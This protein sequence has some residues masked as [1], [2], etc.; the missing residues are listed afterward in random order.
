[1]LKLLC[2]GWN[3][4]FYFR[5]GEISKSENHL[6]GRIKG[7]CEGDEKKNYMEIRW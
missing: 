4:I 2:E 6:L 7:G 5:T 3:D 1:M